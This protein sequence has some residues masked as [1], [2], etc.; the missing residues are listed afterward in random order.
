YTAFNM[1]PGGSVDKRTNLYFVKSNDMGETWHT[2]DGTPLETPLADPQGPALV[3]D[4]ESEGR[5]VYMK[6]TQF[7]ADGNPI[8]LIVTSSHHMPG[9]QGDP[10]TWTVVHWNGTAWQ[11]HDVT[12]STHNYDMG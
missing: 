8:L 2:V 7:D 12:T 11:F 3:R 10:R 5:L 6:D 1:H 4:Y 9:P